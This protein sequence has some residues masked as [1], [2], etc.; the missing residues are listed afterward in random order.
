M[1]V[2]SVNEHRK[3][4]I[5]QTLVCQKFGRDIT[6]N[7]HQCQQMAHKTATIHG[8]GLHP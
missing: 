4:R 8:K 2:T 1:L 7:F 5:A 6:I 3:E